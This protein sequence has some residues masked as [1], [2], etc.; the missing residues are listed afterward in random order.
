MNQILGVL[1]V[2]K[3]FIHHRCTYKFSAFCVNSQNIRQQ[4]VTSI[5][6]Y[7]EGISIAGYIIRINWHIQEVPQA[8][9]GPQKCK[10][11]NLAACFHRSQYKILPLVSKEA[12]LDH[13]S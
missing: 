13:T 7:N 8:T 6:F 5:L 2:C 3:P 4:T 9:N 12:K 1:H 10:A 11:T